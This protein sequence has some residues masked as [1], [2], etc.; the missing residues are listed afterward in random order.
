MLVPVRELAAARFERDTDAAA[1][2][3]AH[4]AYYVR[5]AADIEPLLRGATQQA[6]VERL[7]AERETSAPAFGISSR[8]AR[9]TRSPMPCGDC[10]LY[11][12]IRNLLPTAKGWTDELLETGVPLA[13]RTRAIAI[14]FSSWVALAIPG[15]EVDLVPLRRPQRCSAPRATDSAKVRR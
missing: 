14:T 11:W 6:A 1:V 10:C 7:E 2:R 9:S 4:A 5:L 3:G 15:T 8:W 12:W 13:D